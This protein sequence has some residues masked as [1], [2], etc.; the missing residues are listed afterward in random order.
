MKISFEQTKSFSP[1]A[2]VSAVG[3]I[4]IIYNI[5]PLYQL[6]SNAYPSDPMTEEEA[7]VITFEG[8][9]DVEGMHLYSPDDVSLVL[10][11][12]DQAGLEPF[13]KIVRERLEQSLQ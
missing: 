6:W 12:L 13:S 5:P 7:A 8:V 4:C 9:A 3:F 11:G 2:L 10:D 1:T